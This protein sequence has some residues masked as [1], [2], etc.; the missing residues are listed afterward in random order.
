VRGCD[1]DSVYVIEVD[2]LAIIRKVRNVI[3]L[4]YLHRHVTLDVTHGRKPAFLHPLHG[5]G[6]A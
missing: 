6:V 2:Q 5:S 3:L 4:P 1:D